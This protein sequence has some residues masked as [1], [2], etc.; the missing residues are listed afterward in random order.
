LGSQRGEERAS[1]LGAHQPLEV[2]EH[3]RAAVAVEEVGREH[4]VAVS[5]QAA[6][7]LLDRRPQS[8]GVGVEHDRR[9]RA[10]AGGVREE[11]VRDPLRC[12]DVD[13]LAVD[14]L[15]LRHGAVL[16]ECERAQTRAA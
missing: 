1:V 8:V 12:R 13:H 11:R 15:R 14:A 5:G 9:M 2:F 16:L 4:A 7:V 3:R 6:H 10:A